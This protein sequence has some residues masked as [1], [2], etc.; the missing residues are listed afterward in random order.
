MPNGARDYR[1]P[2]SDRL[3]WFAFFWVAN[4]IWLVLPLAVIRSM[5]HKLIK[6]KDHKDDISKN[7]AKKNKKDK[8]KKKEEKKSKED[9][10]STTDSKKSQ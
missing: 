1:N 4:G 9:K 10:K 8:K 7:E 5:W 2:N 6:N 3:T